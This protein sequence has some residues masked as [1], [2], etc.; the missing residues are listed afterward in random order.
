MSTSGTQ[1]LRILLTLQHPAHVH[2]FKHAYWEQRASTHKVA[3][4]ARN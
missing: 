3:V 2:F 4:V 1:S